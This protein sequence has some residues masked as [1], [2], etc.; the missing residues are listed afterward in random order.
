MCIKYMS[1]VCECLLTL[2][3][4][5]SSFYIYYE[6]DLENDTGTIFSVVPTSRVPTEIVMLRSRFNL[7]SNIRLK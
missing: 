7:H 2:M 4:R 1:I 6:S 5:T 3:L